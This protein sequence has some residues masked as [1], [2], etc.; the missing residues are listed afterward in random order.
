MNL[1]PDEKLLRWYLLGATS[2]EED[3][4]IERN[5]QDEGGWRDELQLVEEDLIDDYARGGLPVYERHL[6]EE[7]FLDNPERRRKL[8]IAQAALN[9]AYTYGQAEEAAMRQ[10]IRAAEAQQTGEQEIGSNP[11]AV[12]QSGVAATKHDSGPRNRWAWLFAPAWKPAL[13]VVLFLTA[14]IGI[15]RLMQGE[16]EVRRGM[17]A[18]NQAYSTTR[19]LEARI[20]A[21]NY[22][23]FSPQRGDE[24]AGGGEDKTARLAGDRAGMILLDA[25]SERPS[26]AARHALGRLYLM[27][28]EFDKAIDQFEEALKPDPDNTGLNSDLGAALL[29]KATFERPGGLPGSSETMLAN[30]LKYLNKALELDGALLEAR[31][32]RA[33]LYQSLGLPPRAIEDWQKYLESDANSQWA[34]EARRNLKALEEQNKKV[35]TNKEDLYRNFL[36]AWRTNKEEDAWHALRR[37]FLRNGNH[38]TDRLIDGFLELSIKGTRAEASDKLQGLSYAGDLLKRRGQDS[39][40]YNLA[41]FYGKAKKQDLPRLSQARKLAA[42]G[43]KFYIQSQTDQ[44]IAKYSQAKLLFEQSGNSSETLFMEYCIGLCYIRIPD[45]TRSQNALTQVAM[46]SKENSF[47]WLHAGALIGLTNT[48]KWLSEFSKAADSYQLAKDL[49]HRIGDGNGVSLNLK[50][51]A[52]LYLQLGKYND[53][54]KVVREGLSLSR[55]ISADASETATLYSI[56]AWN[57]NA[58]GLYAAAL[59]Y[60]KEALRLGNDLQAASRNYVHLGLIY[61]RLESYDEAI[62]NI[63]YGME[64][65]KTVKPETTAQDMVNYASLYLGHVYRRAR[66]YDDS[67]PAITQAA[68]FY[69]GKKAEAL[70]YKALKEKLLIHI[71]RGDVVAAREELPHTLELFEEHRAKILEESNRNSFFDVEQ[72][73]YDVAINFAFTQLKD[74]LQ[75]LKYSELSR[76]RSLL[77]AVN[78]KGRLIGTEATPDLRFTSNTEPISPSEIQRRIPENTQILEYAILEDKLIIW[79][80]SKTKLEGRVVD[81]SSKELTEKLSQYLNR[82]SNPNDHDISWMLDASG[83]LY[84]ILVRPVERI[85]D[86]DRLICIVPD[87]ILYLLPFESI[88]SRDSGKYLLEEYSM[89]YASSANL[90]LY[91]SE[92]ARRKSRAQPEELLSVGNP[93]FDRRL[94]PDLHDLRF[95]ANEAE[96]I[97][98]YY[99]KHSVFVDDKAM[100][101]AILQG[102]K[103]SD[104]VHLALHYVPHPQSP[105][106]SQI[107]LAAVG[108]SSQRARGDREVLAAYE[109]YRLNMTRTRLIVL[110]GCQTGVDTWF[111][112]E[113]PVGLS[114]PFLAAGIPLTVASLWPV[115]D[116]ATTELMINFHKGR[117]SEGLSTVKSLQLAKLSL[118]KGPET[119]YRH[120]YYWAPFTVT[121]GYSEF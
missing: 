8:L 56:G 52:H 60:Q 25:V 44:A 80:I 58:L 85:L 49:S 4:Q 75:A 42:E 106:L 13:L 10:S 111:K 82:I 116:S 118:L 97:T 7:N 115:D 65:G 96:S 47:H 21:L 77:D 64:I 41:R 78:I 57:Y 110:S 26:P 45:I 112:G 12:Q 94:F 48:Y 72:P 83:N 62:K 43:H 11:T 69:A 105:M 99:P 38:V 14:G 68:E 109:I 19:P 89:I 15:W 76:A 95:A 114:R 35:L 107:P 93:R 33:L 29:E 24:K 70:L 84:D 9:Y 51:L 100:K 55:Q 5:L 50:H 6:F 117:K 121:G 90:F 87:K 36:E 81:V 119:K 17:A 61:A 59:D 20:T 31:F 74:P 34:G 2:H 3:A 102:L 53:S 91:C 27:K 63:K 1:Q 18:L 46:A 40:I 108:N 101:P 79:L 23:A 88:F 67:I 71:A 113:G 32:N 30:S 28:K 39:F 104:V 120:P 92:Q 16:L 103:D 37:S 66:L 73:I 54:L 86:K 98:A 22:A